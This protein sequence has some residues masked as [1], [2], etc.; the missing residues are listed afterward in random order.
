[1]NGAAHPLHAL[2]HNGQ[3][4]TAALVGLFPGRVVAVK[5]VK[6][7]AQRLFRDTR[8]V[9]IHPEQEVRPVATS[10]EGDM[11]PLPMPV[12]GAVVQQVH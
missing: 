11:P 9:I 8:A 4:K 12:F 5:H 10:G 6:Q 2:G 7:L 1:M 3:P